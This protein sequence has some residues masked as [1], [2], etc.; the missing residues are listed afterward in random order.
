MEMLPSMTF[1]SNMSR[2]EALPSVTSS[3]QTRCPKWEKSLPQ[4]FVIAATEEN[5]TSLKLKVE[6][7]TMDTAE[8]KSISALVDCG[9]TGE[10]IDRH[11]AKSSCFNLVKLTQP[12]PVYN[13]NGTLNEAG[14][15][16][17]VVSP[18]LCYKNHSERT[19]FAVCGLGKQK[20]IL[21]HSWLWKHNPEIDWV[22]QEVKMSR[23]PPRSCP[24]CRDEVCQEHAAQKAESQRNDICTAG[25]SLRLVTAPT[26]LMKMSLTYPQNLCA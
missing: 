9:A 2:M 4:K 12:I 7:E 21:G 23:C 17:E 8:K 18:I 1:L 15:I 16:T 26:L 14:S 25:P 3:V 5:P 13:I 11:Y 22:T 20:L 24:G 10:F 6:I 19:T